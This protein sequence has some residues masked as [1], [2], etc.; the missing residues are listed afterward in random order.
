MNFAT[1]ISQRAKITGFCTIV[2]DTEAH[3]GPLIIICKGAEP[4]RSS[5][6]TTTKSDVYRILTS[7]RKQFYDSYTGGGGG[8]VQKLMTA[9]QE[10]K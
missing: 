7:G 1:F 3:S 8:G 2:A 10:L 4:R 5:C 6:R 9:L